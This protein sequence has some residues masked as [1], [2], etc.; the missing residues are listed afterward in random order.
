[1]HSL[2]IYVFHR[3]WCRCFFG[4][5]QGGIFSKCIN[6]VGMFESLFG[7]REDGSHREIDE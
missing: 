3:R 5:F 2:I 7:G 1:M 6:N 4:G